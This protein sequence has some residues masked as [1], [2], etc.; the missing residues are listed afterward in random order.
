MIQLTLRPGNR[1]GK[2]TS[3]SPRR[4]EGN[5]EDF[6]YDR[7]YDRGMELGGNSGRKNLKTNCVA[8]S[9]EGGSQ[10]CCTHVLPRIL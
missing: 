9:L 8:K 2:T 10:N 5:R 6:Q 3:E 7:K 4:G 1:G